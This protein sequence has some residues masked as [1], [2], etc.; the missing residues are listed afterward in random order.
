MFFASSNSFPHSR[1][2]ACAGN[3]A[4][5]AQ[6]PVRNT[7]EYE[8]THDPS[9]PSPTGSRVCNPNGI[10]S[11]SPGLRGTSYPGRPRWG[12]TSWVMFPK[13]ACS[14][15]PWALGRNPFGIR[16]GEAVAKIL[17]LLCRRI[18]IGGAPHHGGTVRVVGGLQPS[19]SAAFAPLHL[20]HSS[21]VPTSGDA[22]FVRASKRRERRAPWVAAPPL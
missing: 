5:G 10:V 20:W 7:Y 6:A 2:S 19:R 11:S 21:R 17:N 4:V 22:L 15:Q 16:L 12:C 3:P 14:S 8:R 9:P 18:A 1:L 13:V